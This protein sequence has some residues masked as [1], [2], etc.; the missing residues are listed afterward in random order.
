VDAFLIDSNVLLDFLS[1]DAEWFDWSAATLE[2][3]AQ[4]GKLVL[5]PIIYTEV[6][7]GFETIEDVEEALPAEFL[8]REPIPVEA[9]FLAGKVFQRYRKRGGLKRSPL[10]DF[11]I[12]AHAA[13]SGM[14]LVTRD[15]RRYRSYFPTLEIIAP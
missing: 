7:I 2:D 9:A 14:T 13:V 1:E 15:A 4:R 12:G 10:P 8:V 5:N 3:V 6:S 11:Y